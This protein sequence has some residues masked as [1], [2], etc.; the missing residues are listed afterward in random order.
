MDFN[1]KGKRKL[2]LLSWACMVMPGRDGY[3]Y[4]GSRQKYLNEWTGQ[5]GRRLLP[6]AE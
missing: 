2:F 1:R 3:R 6:G 5:G 4:V